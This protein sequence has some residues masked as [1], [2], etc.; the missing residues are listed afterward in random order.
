[1]GEERKRTLTVAGDGVLVDV[2]FR[3]EEV[4]GVVLQF[5]GSG[6]GVVA[7]ARDAAEV[8]AKNLKG[9][10][11]DRYVALDGFVGNLQRLG[12]MDRLGG[13][14]VNCFDATDGIYR[15]LEKVFSWDLEDWRKD[16]NGRMVTEVMCERSGRPKMHT[17]GHVG[18]ALQYW[19]ERRLVHG[20]QS[21]ADDMDID[22]PEAAEN[23]EE[24]VVWLVIIECE[25]SPG[26]LYP[27]IRLSDAWASKAVEKPAPTEI[28][29]LPMDDASID[30]QD[31]PALFLA[32]KSPTN[33][34]AALSIENAI[35][36]R[37]PD[38]RFV[39]KFEPPVIVP[40]QTAIQLHISVG[41][42]LS[43][44]SLL[45]T[46]Y[47]S[48][49]FADIDSQRPLLTSPRTVEKTVV[50]CD[51]ATETSTS[52]I[53]RSSLLTQ[54]NDYA[55]AITHL[56][57]SHPRQI[58]ALLPTLRQ[59]ALTAS[60]LRR[61][62]VAEPSIDGPAPNLN[63]LVEQ[64]GDSR[65]NN[66]T[67]PPEPTTFQTIDAELADFMASPLPNDPAANAAAAAK[68]KAI[69]ITL[70]TTPLPRLNIHFPNPRF[71]GKL[72]S[73]GFNVGL[74]GMIAGIDVDDGS[75]P[76]DQNGF[77]NSSAKAEAEARG[78]ERVRLRE[79]VKKVLEV[80][81][82]IGVCVEWMTRK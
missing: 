20:E 11:D 22:Q 21:T 71:G 56:P 2:E 35:Q 67:Q 73:I 75:P 19:M 51:P 13:A 14:E 9:N 5:E 61:S 8:L 70:T 3:G 6:K 45:P 23:E 52:H 48:L 33:G 42:P 36:P 54:P 47:E 4:R 55:R 30:W 82:S 46:T 37:S 12:T 41:A 43:Q 49:V 62:F 69:D 76:W 59:W 40:L 72:A 18:L 57:F 16:G 1:M 32:P 38:I 31:P 44:Q 24:S 63:G 81:E 78:K 27:P 7:G 50:S 10:G 17:R 68:V 26:E 53:H 25:A 34:A 65:P 79:K 64:N 39:A 74:N 58:I 60:L 28:T 66:E 15:S 80:G 77:D 29:D